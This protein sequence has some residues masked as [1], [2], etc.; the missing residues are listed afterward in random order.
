M[1]ADH[2]DTDKLTGLL[3][4]ALG[5]DAAVTAVVSTSIGTGQVGE[6][7]RFELE[8]NDDDPTLPQTVV[9]KF[10]SVSEVSRATAVQLDTYVKEVGFYRDLQALVGIRTPR[11]Y[12]L[13]WDPPT[14][15]FVLLMEDIAPARA[16][17]QLAGADVEAA[18]LAVDQAV[19]LHAPTWGHVP[20]D[21]A[22]GWL[23]GSSGPEQ[24]TTRSKMFELLTPGFV[25]RFSAR[26]ERADLEL[27]HSLT[28]MF[29]RWMEAVAGWAERHGGWCVVH[30]DFRLDNMLFGEPPA[31]PPL[32]VVD[33]QTVSV[34]IG[35][36]D[37][38][39]YC[40]AGLLPE[41][42]ASHERSLVERY[43]AGVRRHGVDIADEAVWEGY[44]LGSATGYFMAVLA[45]QIVERTERG[46]EMFAVMAERHADQI[47]TV[48]LLERLGVV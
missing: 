11:V 37:V 21:P 46:D 48:G 44:V 13:E 35:P 34:G 29:P 42:R 47:R 7:V 39:Y 6:N 22:F 2:I 19:G 1:T 17:D 28:V 16:G 23:V 15:D 10:P 3:G 4:R 30:G 31:S 12:G 27:A 26:L 43:A 20:D 25:D 41:V 18:R 14:H 32:T 36:N 9:G 33:W 40:G 38:A 45:S 24:V 8:W 5:T